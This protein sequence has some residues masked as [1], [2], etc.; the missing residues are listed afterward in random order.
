[1]YIKLQLVKSIDDASRVQM[2]NRLLVPSHLDY[3][4]DY[5]QSAD[6]MHFCRVIFKTVYSG[7]KNA[8]CTYTMRCTYTF[9]SSKSELDLGIKKSKVNRSYYLNIVRKE[10]LLKET[11]GKKPISSLHLPFSKDNIT[12]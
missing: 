6:K 3:S 2:V 10:H 1:M 4:S 8:E 11:A 7:T 12:I 5:L 9:E